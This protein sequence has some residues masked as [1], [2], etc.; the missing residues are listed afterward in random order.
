[1]TAGPHPGVL[2]DLTHVQ[3][4]IASYQSEFVEDPPTHGGDLFAALSGANPRG[5]AFLEEKRLQDGID[6]WGTPY[7]V[8]HSG[9]GWLIRSAGRDQVFNDCSW[10]GT[11]DIL[12]RIPKRTPN[13]AEP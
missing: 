5:L 6:P 10:N 7:E 2:E 12:L 9:D 13:Q 1:M 3:A 4:A 11:D 8:W